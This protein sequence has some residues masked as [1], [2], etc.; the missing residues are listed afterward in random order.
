MKIFYKSKDL[1]MNLKVLCVL[2][3]LF[4]F[5]FQSISQSTIYVKYSQ[6]GI[7]GNLVFKAD[8]AGIVSWVKDFSGKIVTTISDTNHLLTISSDGNLLYLSSMQTSGTGILH[9]YPSIIVM[10]TNGVV[11]NIWYQNISPGNSYSIHY[12]IGASLGG[13]W[14]FDDYSPGNTHHFGSNLIDTNGV[15]SGGVEVWRGS[16]TYFSSIKLMSDSSYLLSNQSASFG[17]PV[18][19]TATKINKQGFPV[20]KVS[21][22]DNLLSSSAAK[23]EVDSLNNTILF[24]S[25]TNNVNYY[26]MGVILNPNGVVLATR[27]WPMSSIFC[28]GNLEFANGKIL[29]DDNTSLFEFNYQLYD[30]CLGPGITTTASIVHEQLNTG[31]ASGQILSSFLPSNHPTITAYPFSIQLPPRQISPNY[32]LTLESNTD[33][34]NPGSA[35][36]VFPNPVIETLKISCEKEVENGIFE[37]FDMNGSII[38]SGLFV[39]EIDVTELCT[40]IYFLRIKDKN[41]SIVEKFI[42]L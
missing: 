34:I 27:V 9:Y 24:F 6:Y 40:G 13:S 16:N 8:T 19:A 22:I 41:Y 28:Y 12:S 35:N 7:R 38:K 20:W 3:F 25:L 37:L 5:S 29:F 31:T 17:P 10:D 42:K 32:C 15:F 11:R 36:C 21:V 14:I 30:S 1:F 18:V 26:T 39:N 2:T 33:L 4:L 23:S